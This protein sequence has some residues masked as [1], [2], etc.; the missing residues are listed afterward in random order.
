MPDPDDQLQ[1]FNSI[2]LWL[3]DQNVPLRKF[4]KHD[5]VNPWFTLDIERAIIERNIAYRFWR[6]RK[7]TADR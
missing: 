6:R 4:V 1:L 5:P 2:I 7:T 3:L